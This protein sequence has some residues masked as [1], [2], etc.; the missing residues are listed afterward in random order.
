[1]AGFLRSGT[2]AYNLPFAI[3]GMLALGACA[4][5]VVLG[6]KLRAVAAVVTHSA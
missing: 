3:T 2:G 6:L 5:V 4:I 1:M